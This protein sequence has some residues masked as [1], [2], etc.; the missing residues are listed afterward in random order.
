MQ[1][2]IFLDPNW[3]REQL[4]AKRDELSREDDATRDALTTLKDEIESARGRRFAGERIDAQ[5]WA[6]AN[7]QARTMGLRIQKLQG[8]LGEI[9][10]RIRRIDGDAIRLADFA[11]LV[12]VTKQHISPDLFETIWTDFAARK[13]ARA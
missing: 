7:N 1:H 13:N 5:W 9:G 6:D 12:E 3:T 2:D 8:A 11:I 4:I 10:R